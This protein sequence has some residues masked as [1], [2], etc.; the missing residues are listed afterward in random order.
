MA[1]E[2]SILN[3]VLNA[4]LEELMRLQ[5]VLEE[6]HI[7]SFYCDVLVAYLRHDL[8]SLRQCEEHAPSPLLG[9]LVQARIHARTQT[10]D[11]SLLET[12]KGTLT[13]PGLDD[14]WK[15]EIHFV[16]ANAYHAVEDHQASQPHYKY[17]YR[18]FDGAGVDRKA[19]KALQ[20]FVAAE[21][22]IH[23]EKMLLL[24]YE[25]VVKQA[26]QVGELG[27]AGQAC[28]NIS[29]E[30]QMIGALDVALRYCQKGLQWMD[31]DR[32]TLHYY[33]ALVHRCHLYLELGR[34]ED[35]SLDYQLASSAD[36]GEIHAA[37]AVI[38][39]IQGKDTSISQALE[40]KLNLN[41]KMRLKKSV[42]RSRRLSPMESQ[43]VSVL[44]NGP[45]DKFE[46]MELLYGKSLDLIH[47]E[48][49]FYVFL[50]RI[51]KKMPNLI[52][53][54][55]GKYILRDNEP[56]LDTGGVACI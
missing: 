24:D 14:A 51:R 10:I 17:A 1:A 20:N 33:L 47:A 42:T 34:F 27:M 53:E 11:P 8:P 9:A 2:K 46:L 29:R 50:S 23:P 25:F 28:I 19:V 54:E 48:N 37:L 22:R 26:L 30:Y 45:A 38:R 32:G 16:L 21:S 36:F 52:R 7:A 55:S 12:L 4:S 6:S 39:V 31:R 13:D 5:L 41:W 15:G 40:R 49:R 44:S 35:A 43:L 3:K 56:I 18:F